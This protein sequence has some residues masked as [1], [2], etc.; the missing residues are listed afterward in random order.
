MGSR[1][2]RLVVKEYVQVAA[3]T[4]KHVI[5][6]ALRAAGQG[7]GACLCLCFIYLAHCFDMGLIH[8]GALCSVCVAQISWKFLLD[9]GVE[10]CAC[11]SSLR[12]SVFFARHK[13]WKAISFEK[14][15][16]LSDPAA[17]PSFSLLCL[18]WDFGS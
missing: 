6:P 10:V 7:Q 17:C 4:G 15:V 2:G 1:V 5:G 18:L 3:G 13:F 9:S 14:Y 8:E 11:S 16:E 12:A